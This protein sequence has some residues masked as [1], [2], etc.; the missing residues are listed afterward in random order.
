MQHK[1]HT[2]THKE[3]QYNPIY[4][5]FER[6]VCMKP[7]IYWRD[8]KVSMFLFLN[9]NMSCFKKNIDELAARNWSVMISALITL[10]IRTMAIFNSIDWNEI[11]KLFTSCLYQY[12]QTYRHILSYIL[13][14]IRGFTLM[15]VAPQSSFSLHPFLLS[16][17]QIGTHFHLIEMLHAIIKFIIL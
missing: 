3:F 6:S 12:F 13:V 11:R 8:L 17:H 16:F 15:C 4:L 7:P 10:E 1:I 9:E 5:M 14:K 2:Y